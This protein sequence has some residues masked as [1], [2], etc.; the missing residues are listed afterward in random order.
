MAPKAVTPET[1]TTMQARMAAT[2]AAGS[3]RGRLVFRTSPAMGGIGIEG[4]SLALA[5]EA[6]GGTGAWFLRF[7]CLWM[8][9]TLHTTSMTSSFAK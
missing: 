6:L 3:V 1:S 4:Y 7:I 9:R 5:S 8:A 2:A